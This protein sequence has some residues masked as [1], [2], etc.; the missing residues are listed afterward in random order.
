MKLHIVSDLHNE[1]TPHQPAPEVAAA[2]D[3]IVLAGDI[4]LGTKELAWARDAFPNRE[5]VYVAGNHEFSITIGTSCR[6]ICAQKR[7]PSEFISLR[8]GL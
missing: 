8:T 1:F 5:V 4:D 3:V 2:A 7:G 6:L